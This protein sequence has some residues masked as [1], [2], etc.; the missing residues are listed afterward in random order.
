MRL[1]FYLMVAAALLPAGAASAVAQ[2]GVVYGATYVEVAP[3]ATSQAIELLKALVTASRKEDGNLRFQFVQERQRPN[4]FVVIEAWKDQAAFE[5][6]RKG[7]PYAEF[8]EKLGPI[9]NAPPDER[10]HNALAA[11]NMPGPARGALWIITHV[12]VPP[13][14]KDACITELKTLT[15]ASRKDSGNLMFEVVQQTNR[16]NHF[17]VVEIWK[18]DKALD[19]HGTAEHTRRF[20]ANLGPM[21]GAPYEDRVYMTVE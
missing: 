20:R 14:S 7:K 4:R 5:G 8:N 11:A 18:D 12:D 2:E 19:A 6:H 21:L 1:A 16:P 9:R 10:V 3:G 13:P 15:D 17:T